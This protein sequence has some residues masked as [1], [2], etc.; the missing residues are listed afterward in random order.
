MRTG[1]GGTANP[2]TALELVL[3]GCWS[4]EECTVQVRVELHFVVSAKFQTSD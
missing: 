4:G 2:M 1:N 3:R